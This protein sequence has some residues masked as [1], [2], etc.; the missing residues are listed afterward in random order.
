MPR[1]E[2]DTQFLLEHA[3]LTAQRRLR[4]PQSVGGL[5]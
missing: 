1:E 2:L 3:D 5:A 4:D